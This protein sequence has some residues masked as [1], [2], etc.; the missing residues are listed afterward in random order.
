MLIIL[1]IL[2]LIY[3]FY[4][5]FNDGANA[6]ATTVAT[7]AMKPR[8]AIYYAA[9]IM[10]ITPIVMYFI[11][12]MAV[13]DT[14]REDIIS[15]GLMQSING[16]NAFALICGGLIAALLWG[17][18]AYWFALPNSSSHTLFGGIIGASISIG[19][20]SSIQWDNVFVKLI[21]MVI[22]AP[23]VGM[24]FGYLFMALFKKIFYGSR[25]SAK[26]VFN[27]LQG[28]N[29]LFLSSSISINIVQ[30]SIGVTM[31]ACLLCAGMLETEMNAVMIY[32]VLGIAFCVALGL[33]LG[34]Y[35]IIN[36][37]GSKIFKLG[38]L[39]AFVTQITTELV[40][41]S[42]S[43]TGIPI[44]TG[45]VVSSTI[46]GVGA[47]ESFYSVKWITAKRIL[48]SWLV[49]FPVSTCIG[50]LCGFVIKTLI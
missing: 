23:V 48:F 21:L 47:Q 30:K 50:V 38:T 27:F 49:T 16:S 34:G 4:M 39:Q 46:M 41:F 43:I 5:G 36:T 31:L 24:I 20:F 6:I 45:Q 11:G 17:G 44:S 42:A 33:V 37:V 3:S 26:K 15:E 25:R 1:I 12:S 28:V 35:R 14:I 40:C 9:T 32:F 8:T 13:A 19:G 2:I 29:V 22:L 10:L 7:R 18:V